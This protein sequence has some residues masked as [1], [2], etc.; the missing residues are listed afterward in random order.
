MTLEYKQTSLWTAA[1]GG[2]G[3]Q[4]ANQKTARVNL[5]V[6]LGKLDQ[7]IEPRLATIDVSCRE[8]TIH[9][10]SHVHQ[11]WSVASQIC[12]PDYLLNP[13]EGFVLGACPHSEVRTII[14][15]GSR[16]F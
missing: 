10:I 7:R 8:L 16:R 5:L 3:L 15:T 11:L 14:G 9:D 4:T 2:E 12:G 6:Q 1:F 13:L